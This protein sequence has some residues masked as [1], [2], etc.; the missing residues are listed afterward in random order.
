MEKLK[1]CIKN[2]SGLK[3]IEPSE[4]IGKGYLSMAEES[5]GT[6]VREKNKNVRA[7]VSAG[8]YSVYYSLYSIMQK[9]GVKC[10]I[11]TCSFEFMKKFLSGFYSKKECDFI[12]LAFIARQNL[13]YY[14]DR[15]VN[16]EDI[17]LVLNKSYDFFVLSR[18]IFSKLKNSEIKKI[19][20]DFS[21]IAN[22]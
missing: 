5:L 3:L 10:E 18:E 21:L 17:D 11:H 6:L 22:E 2:K 20:E 1:W 8:Y 14:V 19:R 9:I 13:Q 15:N 7:A 4:K 12:E 16:K